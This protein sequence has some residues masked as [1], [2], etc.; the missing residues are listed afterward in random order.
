RADEPLT[1]ARFSADGK[2]I[3]GY[4]GSRLCVWN[5]AD[6]SLVR[7]IDTGLQPLD[8]PGQHDDGQPAFAAHPKERRV[9]V[10]GAR[11]G[12]AILQVW[13]FESGKR[14]AEQAS[15]YAALKLIAWTPDGTRLLER[16]N[17][18]WEKPDA[19]KLIV[20]DAHL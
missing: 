15:P 18:R 7:T 6:G 17:S 2:Q 11:D 14:L 16:S 13:D 10:A 12:K 9:A 8:D 1:D 4:T 19:Y 3:V 20:R 5:A